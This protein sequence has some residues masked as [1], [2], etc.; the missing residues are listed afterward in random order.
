MLVASRSTQSIRVALVMAALVNLIL[1]VAPASARAEDL[2]REIVLTSGSAQFAT[3]LRLTLDRPATSTERQ[4]IARD[5]SAGQGT[6]AQVTPMATTNLKCSQGYVKVTNE[7]RWEMSYNCYPEYATTPW[8]FKISSNV[9]YIIVS[10]VT[11]SGLLWWRNG[12]RQ[13]RLAPH[14]EP[15]GYLFHGTMKKM[16]NGDAIDYQDYFTF[17]HNVNGGGTGSITIAGSYT[18]G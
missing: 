12:T 9:Q 15:K 7:G 8:S 6:Q 13:P 2:G 16:W 18:V 14:T 1:S 17:R 10:P 3:T 11:E 5:L 4:K